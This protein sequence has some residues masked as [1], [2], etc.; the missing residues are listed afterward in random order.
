[1][2]QTSIVF[3]FENVL[4]LY[5]LFVCFFFIFAQTLFRVFLLS[6]IKTY[7]QTHW[8]MVNVALILSKYD[9]WTLFFLG[10]ESLSSR[11]TSIRLILENSMFYI[12]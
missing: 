2:F 11:A 8:R 7:F 5:L 6:L 12:D 3:I 10:C 4:K 1:M 9:C